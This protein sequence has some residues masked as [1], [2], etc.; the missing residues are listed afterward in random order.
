MSGWFNVNKAKYGIK[1]STLIKSDLSL[2]SM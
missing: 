2:V 1:N